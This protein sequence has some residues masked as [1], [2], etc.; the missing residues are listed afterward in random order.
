MGPVPSNGDALKNPTFYN[1]SIFL[2]MSEVLVSSKCFSLQEFL[3]IS[4]IETTPATQ[5]WRAGD[6]KLLMSGH[7]KWNN[8]QWK[9]SISK[10]YHRAYKFITCVPISKE[11]VDEPTFSTVIASTPVLDSRETWCTWGPCVYEHTMQWGDSERQ[12]LVLYEFDCISGG[13]SYDIRARNF[14]RANLL[15]SSLGSVNQVI[16]VDCQVGPCILLRSVATLAVYQ[17]GCITTLH[18]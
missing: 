6:E 17:N 1:S 8:D 5:F 12:C 16:A 4:N 14:S 2:V 13:Q 9:W 7:S 11:L 10:T 3:T 15:H 18:K